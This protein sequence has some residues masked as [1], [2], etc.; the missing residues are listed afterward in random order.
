M[1]HR[2]STVAIN[3]FLEA[4]LRFLSPH[5]EV[6]TDLGHHAGYYKLLKSRGARSYI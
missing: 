1:N 2:I 6:S 3:S 4:Q 5:L